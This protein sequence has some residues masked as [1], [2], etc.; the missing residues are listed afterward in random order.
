MA[1]TGPASI[2]N[3]DELDKMMR[4]PTHQCFDTPFA[5]LKRWKA[6]EVPNGA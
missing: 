3:I 1:A 2:P 4:K 5:L 6:T